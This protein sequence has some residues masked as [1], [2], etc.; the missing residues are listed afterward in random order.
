VTESLDEQGLSD[1]HGFLKL[2]TRGG[3]AAEAAAAKLDAFLKDGTA[4]ADEDDFAGHGGAASG[5]GTAG[6]EGGFKKLR[7]AAGNDAYTNACRVT[8]I[9]QLAN[10]FVTAV[11]YLGEGLRYGLSFKQDVPTPPEDA[12][13]TADSFVEMA[14]GMPGA[15]T[16]AATVLRLV[17]ALVATEV[18]AEPRVRQYMREIFKANALLYTKP[19]AKGL[20]TI[21][22]FH[23]LF[24]LHMIKGKPLY[25]MFHRDGPSQY[26]KLLRAEKDGLIT[27]SIETPQLELDDGSSITDLDVFLNDTNV[28]GRQSMRAIFMP[29]GGYGGEVEDSWNAQRES[30]L[31][32][33]LSSHLLPAFHKELTR[34]LARKGREQIIEQA[35]I[36]YGS[37]V[38]TAPYRLR[39]EDDKTTRNLL[40]NKL[41]DPHVVAVNLAGA[42]PRSPSCLAAV[43]TS[44]KC[45]QTDLIPH[46][47]KGQ[48]RERI[49]QFVKN[50]L[51][52]VIV[53]N[54]SAGRNARGMKNSIA[55]N[56]VETIVDEKR[57]E[58]RRRNDARRDSMESVNPGRYMD[59]DDEDDEDFEYKPEVILVNDDLARI[60]AQSRRCKTLFPDLDPG[61]AGAACLA[62]YVQDPLAEYCNMWTTCDG[63]GNF[64]FGSL[65]LDLLPQQVCPLH[66]SFYFSP[67]AL[68]FFTRVMFCTKTF[69]PCGLREEKH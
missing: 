56:I 65:F 11:A 3:M 69:F 61:I 29:S 62:R 48:L 38:G 30:I 36:K 10:S 12:T 53:I 5:A 19:T 4:V 25:E 41:E 42:D 44:G 68:F 17:R 32:E 14:K 52:N 55:R 21:G 2:L 35:A 9:R 18:A 45:V 34:E 22:A 13:S 1:V 43:D 6:G 50:T 15:P 63:V 59:L 66:V 33:A 46:R 51:P 16:T 8:G 7:Q 60:F 54:M 58:A 47:A 26:L 23:D 37:L 57:A 20:E 31:R 49:K 67:F 39:A 64:G 27:I 24:G 28:P 40:L